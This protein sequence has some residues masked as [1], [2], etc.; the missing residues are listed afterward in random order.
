MFVLTPEEFGQMLSQAA[1]VTP[2]LKNLDVSGAKDI[3]GKTLVVRPYSS[4]NIMVQVCMSDGPRLK[5]DD[6]VGEYEKQGYSFELE[7]RP[8]SYKGIDSRVMRVSAFPGVSTWQAF[9]YE[10]RCNSL[11]SYTTH[12]DSRE[13]MDQ[14]LGALSIK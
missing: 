14:F 11:V 4:E 6:L 1:T 2:A 12:G 3:S 7:D 5:V 9:I 13:F 8:T 10:D